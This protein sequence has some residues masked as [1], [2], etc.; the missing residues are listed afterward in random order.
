[1][2]FAFIQITDH[3]IQ[4]PETALILGFSTNYS[5]RT[6][7]QHIIE[8]TANQVDFIVSTGDLVEYASEN[9]YHLL[10][11]ILGLKLK[12]PAPGPQLIQMEGLNNFPLYILPG[13]HD[14][15]DC[16]FRCLF[17]LSQPTPLMNTTFIYKGMQFICLD[18][19]AED[20]G[21]AYPETLSFLEL[22]L[23][24]EKPS[25]VLMHH[26]ME[27][28]KSRWLDSLIAD[29]A[30]KFWNII[31][32][33]RVMGIFCGHVHATFETLS[34]KIPVYTVGSTGF[35]FPLQDEEVIH[36][37]PPQYRLVRVM[38]GS[39]YTQVIDVQLEC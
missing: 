5:F 39:I 33:K 22:A 15:R 19:G 11:N 9:N 35:Q 2:D 29:G 3:H 38:D 25:I 24:T 36:L 23:V 10:R 17:P 26:H 16:F 1:M 20:K 21:Y 37:T 30:E 31:E 18:G 34:R 32:N 7:I 6:V 27:P 14:D 28:V 8:H 12:S 13:N 4:S